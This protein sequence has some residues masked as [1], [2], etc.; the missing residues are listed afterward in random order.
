MDRWVLKRGG[1]GGIYESAFVIMN[2]LLVQQEGDGVTES[3]CERGRHEH[4]TPTSDREIT[5]WK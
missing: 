2:P 1:G 3:V 4:F 5:P